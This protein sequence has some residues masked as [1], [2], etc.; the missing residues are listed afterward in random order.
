MPNGRVSV[1]CRVVPAI[2]L[3]TLAACARPRP[4]APGAGIPALPDTVT[5][6]SA[7]RVG[8]VPL[9]DY[10][11]IAALSEIVPSGETG[12]TVQRVY[13]V[14]TLLARTWAVSHRGRHR[15]EGF[16]FCD[17]THCQ[18]YE[19]ARLRT[20]SFRDPAQAATRRTRGQVLIHQQRLIEGLF[21]ADCGGHTATPSLAWSGTNHPYLPARADD[22][23]AGTHRNWQFET[24]MEEW[25]TLLNRD[26]RTA[27]GARFTNLEVTRTAA[28][29]RVAEV[30]LSGT[31][32]KRVSGETLRIVVVAARG[33]QSVMSS[34]FTADRRGA[35]LRLTGRGFGHG[36]GLCQVGAMA[37]ARRGDSVATILGFYFPGSVIFLPQ[38]GK[39]N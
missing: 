10:V 30:L 34:L 16:D 38:A 39:R 26:P 36:V 8:A 4:M 12:P 1:V 11:T 32:P 14:Q 29:G 27:V 31:T 28:G 7:G 24:S 15:A 3:L 21:H 22:L 20:S 23:P 37:R 33:A 9:E 25:R 2:L 19:P 5:V 6:R 17:T 35:T 18:V 13:E